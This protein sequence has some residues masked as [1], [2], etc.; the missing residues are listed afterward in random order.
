[1]AKS[2]P[3]SDYEL[4]RLQRIQRNQDRLASLGLLHKDKHVRRI[5]KSPSRKKSKTK[6][7]SPSPKRTSRRLQNQPAAEAPLLEDPPRITL[8]ERDHSRP[9]RIAED[10]TP[11]LTPE[12]KKRICSR[13]SPDDFLD[14][15]QDYLVNVE[16]ASSANIARVLRSMKKLSSG[17]GVRAPQWPDDCYLLRGQ[18]VGPEANVAELIERGRE[19]EEDW[20]RDLGNGWLYSHPLR[21]LAM[22]QRHL[23]EE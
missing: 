9:R 5:V 16:N 22:F 10:L 2:S 23:L 20:G 1:M 13:V 11:T 12:Q 17:Q 15:L 8:A 14:K 7:V 19:C 18:K 4:L 21:K 6:I 3:L